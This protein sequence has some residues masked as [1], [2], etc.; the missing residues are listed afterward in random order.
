MLESILKRKWMFAVIPLGL[1][2]GYG[3]VKALAPAPRAERALEMFEVFCLPFQ[4]GDTLAPGRLK[5][6]ESTQQITKWLDPETN[7]VLYVDETSCY[8]DDPFQMLSGRDRRVLREK[9]PGL[10]AAYR[11]ELLNKFVEEN[12]VLKWIDGPA[13]DPS[14]WGIGLIL[15]KDDT[16]APFTML[17]FR[18]PI[19]D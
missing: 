4:R 2:L 11:P 16:G 7:L 14:R 19:A 12:G 18:P 10:V 15:T 1:S 3:A 17:N 9:L 8:V 5:K 13:F 6:L